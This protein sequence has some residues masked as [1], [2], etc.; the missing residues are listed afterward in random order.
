MRNT[1]LYQDRPVIFADES[2]FNLHTR[3]SKGRA[4]AGEPAILQ[5]VPKGKRINLMAT[6]SPSGI[7]HHKTWIKT[8]RDTNRGIGMEQFRS[9]ILDWAPKSPRNAVLVLDNAKIH[10]AA[11]PHILRF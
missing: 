2:G 1:L 4:L 10:H 11:P 7:V 9:F 3:K 5:V 8:A 6:L